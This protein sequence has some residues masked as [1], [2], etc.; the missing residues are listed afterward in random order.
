MAC[1]P[2]FG[3][4][5]GFFPGGLDT[6]NHTVFTVPR[7][8]RPGHGANYLPRCSVDAENERSFT[9]CPVQIFGVCT[10]RRLRLLVFVF[11]NRASGNVVYGFEQ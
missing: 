6:G 11:L 4:A 7:V 5:R 1:G 3:R 9:P 10:L 8:K 2:I